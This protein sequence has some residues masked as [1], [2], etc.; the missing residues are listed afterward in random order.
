M[1]SSLFVA[2]SWT[3]AVNTHFWDYVF[4]VKKAFLCVFLQQFKF[5]KT[6]RNL[7]TKFTAFI[8]DPNW[9]Q[10][11]AANEDHFLGKIESSLTTIYAVSK[12]LCTVEQ[13][14]SLNR[15]PAFKTWSKRVLMGKRTLEFL[16]WDAV[17]TN[18]HR[19]F[20][21]FPYIGRS[22]W[23]WFIK[24][25]FHRWILK[26]LKF[27]FLFMYGTKSVFLHNFNFLELLNFHFKF[28]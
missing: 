8:A 4:V 20:W 1:F 25:R 3:E 28:Y 9:T 7:V 23:V 12:P 14:F 15:W 26:V 24:A 18:L 22:N 19:T 6:G 10:R 5:Y 11:L 13:K 21:A 2:T 27:Q 16:K 17:S